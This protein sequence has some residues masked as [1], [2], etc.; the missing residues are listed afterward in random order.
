M[1]V[2]IIFSKKICHDIRYS[3]STFAAINEFCFFYA[4]RPLPSIC[5]RDEDED[6][7]SYLVWQ[8]FR[9]RMK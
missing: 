5:I 7:G 6:W 2:E 4:P 8:Y 3:F 1:S 9:R